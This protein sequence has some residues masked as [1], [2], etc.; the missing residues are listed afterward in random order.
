MG[1]K[2]PHLMKPKVFGIPYHGLVTD[3]TLVLDPAPSDP[4]EPVSFGD[5]IADIS[6]PELDLVT[7][8]TGS[9]IPDQLSERTAFQ[10]NTGSVR[11]LKKTGHTFLKD[12]QLL[13]LEARKGYDLKDYLVISGKRRFV[14]GTDTGGLFDSLTYPNVIETYIVT[15][16]GRLLEVAVEVE[17]LFP[18]PTSS[19]T[20]TVKTRSLA[21]FD[22]SVL[23]NENYTT[24]FSQD[25]ECPNTAT[26]VTDKGVDPEGDI[27]YELTNDQGKNNHIVCQAENSNDFL[28][29][30]YGGVRAI[31][32]SF[33]GFGVSKAYDSDAD[34][35]NSIPNSHQIL[36]CV[37]SLNITGELGNISVDLAVE[38]FPNDLIS[39]S[40]GSTPFSGTG[41]AFGL[42]YT[43]V[44]D[45]PPIFAGSPQTFPG[46][47]TPGAIGFGC[48]AFVELSDSASF[49]ANASSTLIRWFDGNSPTSVTV[50]RN[51]S[52][53][54]AATSSGST[55]GTQTFDCIFPFDPAIPCEAGSINGT[56]SLI[57]IIENSTNN[58]NRVDTDDTDIVL[59]VG[60]DNITLY[61]SDSD[62]SAGN[63]KTCTRTNLDISTTSTPSGSSTQTESGETI[64]SATGIG[65][66]TVRFVYSN[67]GIL[68]MMVFSQ[69]EDDSTRNH[70][71][72]TP[73]GFIATSKS[74]AKVSNTYQPQDD[75]LVHE[76]DGSI[77][78]I[79]V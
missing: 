6:V 55:S 66:F 20:V 12:S 46:V 75:L 4:E 17:S 25:I 56:A 23:K 62:I 22:P 42:V 64:E 24:V 18:E 16:S 69:G 61:S 34:N 8:T 76:S 13:A 26:G 38:S 21:V 39:G 44:G 78:K 41:T 77:K 63:S 32:G 35:P 60:A 47:V 14:A 53:S 30:I 28:I 5:V 48:N 33:A 68:E 58:N 54:S 1:I 70:G 43:E 50:E 29:N 10:L 31:D 45:L 2:F 52:G 57:Q 79:F 51:R 40:A 67:H 49:F 3:D 27:V 19:V 72:I 71:V 7:D 65:T 74:S 36:F 9:G 37:L 11:T 73:K 59:T 15:T